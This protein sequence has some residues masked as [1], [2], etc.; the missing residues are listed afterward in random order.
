MHRFTHNLPLL[1]WDD[2]RTPT[3][4]K[5]VTHPKF[6]MAKPTQ[7]RVYFT[8]HAQAE[9]NVTYDWD[10]PDAPLTP[11]GRHQS[12]LLNRDTKDT[13]QKTAELLVTSALKRP[14]QT[15]VIGYPLLRKRLEEAGKPVVILPQLQECNDCPCDVGSP[16]EE[17]EADPEFAGLDLSL[18]P[19]DWRSK[20]GFYAP[21]A[22]A[23]KE[24]ARWVRRWLRD[25]DECEIVVIAHGDIL[26]YITEGRNSERAWAN[27]EVREYTFRTDDQDA[28][29]VMVPFVATS[30]VSEGDN[31]PTSSSP[32]ASKASKAA[33]TY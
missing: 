10:I 32:V 19:P 13:F 1:I 17:L 24:R 20:E 3:N 21:T 15:M 7:K 29:A 4:A 23:L 9:H 6:I 26:R 30:I 22:A 25:R 12:A 28:D 2:R 5:T 16:R 33:W 8:R 31:E 14:M 18:L 11:H 27:T